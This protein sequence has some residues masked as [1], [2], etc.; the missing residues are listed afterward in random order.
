MA[1]FFSSRPS[2]LQVVDEKGG[3]FKTSAGSYIIGTHLFKAADAGIV[4]LND[5]DGTITLNEGSRFFVSKN[6]V[7]FTNKADANGFTPW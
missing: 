2:H 3:N 4:S 6:T 1:K 5:A 7:F